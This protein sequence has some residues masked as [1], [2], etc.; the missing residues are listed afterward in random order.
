MKIKQRVFT[1]LFMRILYKVFIRRFREANVFFMSMCFSILLLSGEYDLYYCHKCENFVNTFTMEIP[2]LMKMFF[3]DVQATNKG[4]HFHNTI[5][6]KQNGQ[7]FKWKHSKD[8]EW[9][10][11]E[12]RT[13]F[14]IEFIM[15]FQ[16]NI[17]L[18]SFQISK[19]KTS[20]RKMS[21]K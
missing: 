17:F 20:W 19:W 10:W 7:T 21:T 8:F 14:Y 18:L 4:Q 1:S 16:R 6:I 13:T 11:W 5:Q 3:N 12:F 9:I 15:I 2:C